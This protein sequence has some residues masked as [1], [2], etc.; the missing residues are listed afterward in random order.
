[1]PFSGSAIFPFEVR[2]DIPAELLKERVIRFLLE[3]FVE[4]SFKY[5]GDASPLEVS[6]S[7]R[8]LD[9]QIELLIRNNG[10]AVCLSGWWN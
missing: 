6:V 2:F 7:A 1:M 3:P 5:R 9:G 10:E 8:M 4:N